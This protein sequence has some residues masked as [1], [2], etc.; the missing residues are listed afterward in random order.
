MSCEATA[1]RERPGCD[2]GV[3]K[4]ILEFLGCHY[5]LLGFIGFYLV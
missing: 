1:I 3:P 4:P 5:N 2:P